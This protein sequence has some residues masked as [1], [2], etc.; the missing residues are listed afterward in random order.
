MASQAKPLGTIQ[1]SQ[2]ATWGD[3]PT[4][5]SGHSITA[6][7]PVARVDSLGARRPAAGRRCAC[8]CTA[9]P[10]VPSALSC[11]TLRTGHPPF[12]APCLPP[13]H[14]HS[15]VVDEKAV[16]FGGCGVTKHNEPKVFNTTYLL[17]FNSHPMVLELADPMG[18]VPSERW[19]HTSTLMPD[20]AR[21]SHGEHPRR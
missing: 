5:R 4:P 15:Q 6:G 19:R 20:Q 16:V 21:A 14:Q 11:P 8:P 3:K 7:A 9:V 18:V 10:P 13:S 12:P 1:W 2:P 17:K